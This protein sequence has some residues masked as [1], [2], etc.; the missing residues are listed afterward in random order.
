MSECEKYN[1]LISASVDGE[2]SIDDKVELNEHLRSCRQCRS[3]LEMMEKMSSVLKECAE[4]PP[5]NLTRWIMADI[6]PEKRRF[7]GAYGRYTAIAAIICLAVLG[8]S[9]LRPW[10]SGKSGDMKNAENAPPSALSADTGAGGEE[11][12][13]AYV[14]DFSGL[15]AENSI[16]TD[17]DVEEVYPE[18]DS[19]PMADQSDRGEPDAAMFGEE[20]S[21]GLSRYMSLDYDEKFYEV[22]VIYGSVPEEILECEL[23]LD[24]DGE[25]DYKVPKELMQ[26]LEAEGR[27][28]EI[29]YD[30]LVARYGL[31]IILSR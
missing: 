26:S 31:V 28:E 14:S 20:Q 13:H 24:E 27:F 21:R 18:Y 29:Y 10:L 25:K 16:E 30:D 8:T 6:K 19:V 1:T 15:A 2:L 23:L 22:A 12:D 3:Y 17:A 4:E 5:E 11:F 7:F 9:V